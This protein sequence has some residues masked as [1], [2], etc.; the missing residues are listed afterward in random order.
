ME[1]LRRAPSAASPTP[2]DVA[3]AAAGDARAFERLY[4]ASVARVHT[5]ARRWLGSGEAD[6]ATQEVYLRAWRELPRFRGEARF[7]TWLVAV[8]RGVLANRGRAR[9]RR[10]APVPLDG[11]EAAATARAGDW[12]VDL[13]RALAELPD[14]ARQVFLLHDVEGHTHA[15]IAA[16]LG[17]AAGTSKSQLHRARA[18]LRERLYAHRE[19]LR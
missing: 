13:E 2:G 8:A 17:V 4:R 10:P 1:T 15:E 7:E 9:E 14:G 11:S 16:Q 3:A 12:R 19:D 18:L 5:L 6:E